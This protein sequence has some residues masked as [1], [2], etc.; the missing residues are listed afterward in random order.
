MK[1]SESE[2]F[3]GDALT[4]DPTKP[5]RDSRKIFVYIPAAYK[6]GAKAPLLITLDGPNR[7]LLLHNAVDNLIPEN[8]IPTFIQ[9]PLRMAAMIVKAASEDLNTIRCLTASR[10]SKM[11]KCC[12]QY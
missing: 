2:I 10:D 12:M 5:V 4:L 3:R 1:L 7:L 8:R 9:L 11:M 6:N